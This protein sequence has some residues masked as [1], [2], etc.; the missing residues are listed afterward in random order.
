VT[1]HLDFVVVALCFAAIAHTLAIVIL[2]DQH[3]RRAERTLEWPGALA[4][5]YG[6]AAW[7]AWGVSGA[8]TS[9]ALLLVAALVTA[10]L[11]ARPLRSFW[12]AG[13]L[14]LVTH[15]QLLV[16]GLVWGIGFVLTAPV[17]PLTR[18]LMLAALPLLPLTL[19]NGLVRALEG[20]EVL[21]RRTWRRPRWPLVP[22]PRLRYP[23]VSLHV[24]A[25]AEPPEEVIATLDALS[26]LEYP[27]FEVLVIDNN[28]AD[29][30]LWRPVEEHCR[31]LG[32]R[33]RFF[34]LENWPGAK[35]GALNFALTRMAPDAE[36]VSV[37]DA[38]YRADPK[39]L[40]SLIG[41]FDDPRLGFVQ[42]PHAYRG[43]EGSLYQRMCN[44]EYGIFF[45][46]TLRSR[47]ERTAAITVGTMCLIRRRALEEAGGWAEWCVTEDSELAPRIHALG[48]SSIYVN[49]VF[50][51]GLIPDTFAGYK[52]QRFRWT[53]GPVQELKRHFR[54]F[55]PRRWASPSALRPAQKVH[56]M[57]HGLDHVA[58]GA[59]F[60][61]APLGLVS[62]ALMVREGV[63]IPLPA[64][65]WLALTITVPARLLLQWVSYRAA[66]GCRFTD[67]LG[68]LVASRA[69]GHTLSVASVWGVFTRRIPW[70]RT[71]KFK[72]LPMG[73][74][75]LRSARTELTIAAVMMGS[76]ACL[77]PYAGRAGLASM[78][79]LAA[80]LQGSTYLAAP[81]LALLAERDARAAPTVA[82]GTDA[83]VREE[84][85]GRASARRAA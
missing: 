7:G 12:P 78:L 72:T 28:T 63:V 34:H 62:A 55:L 49:A 58:T 38:D 66:L 33:F 37:I 83:D 40:V 61:L 4:L 68:A 67:M 56:H 10:G 82:D 80:F 19:V 16:A 3:L 45:A 11:V 14:L 1:H 47:N 76:A 24:P 73:L 2:A 39:F 13:R 43:W 18:G 48:Y 21:C 5:V 84:R 17:S 26:R 15:V 46:T 8:A 75:A 36:I 25:H 59:G 70:V 31:R 29:P 60:L 23:K 51:R 27:N 52:Q 35:A 64:P 30:A 42:T 81:M 71:N 22:A 41:Y 57:S 74:A 32:E 69:L 85:R 6:G 9:T 53:Y 44:W 50:G 20:S 79:L 77:M 65:V 54:L